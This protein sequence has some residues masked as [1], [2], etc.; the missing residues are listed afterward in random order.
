MNDLKINFMYMKEEDISDELKERFIDI[1][2]QMIDSIRKDNQTY[3]C[4][5]CN[6]TIDLSRTS[7][8]K[9]LFARDSVVFFFYHPN[10]DPIEKHQGMIQVL[11]TI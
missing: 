6:E 9:I 3:K 10:C 4:C 11:I 2:N 8:V 5:Q 7:S 1:K